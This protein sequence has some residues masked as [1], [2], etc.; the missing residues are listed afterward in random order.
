MRLEADNILERPC[1]YEI[2]RYKLIERKIILCQQEEDLAEL[3]KEFI[4][5]VKE[6]KL[7]DE[8]KD[9][10]VRDIQNFKMK[11]LGQEKEIDTVVLSHSLTRS[12]PTLASFSNK[13]DIKYEKNRGR[14]AVANW[15][16]FIS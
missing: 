7:S 8:K 2:I 15:Y 6:S 11:P 1:Q 4:T 13:I 14:F 5:A 9:L 12:H 16:N 3:K 10:H